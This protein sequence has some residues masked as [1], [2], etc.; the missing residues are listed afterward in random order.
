MCKNTCYSVK[1]GTSRATPNRRIDSNQNQESKVPSLSVSISR[2]LWS[3]CRFHNC[4]HL[5]RNYMKGKNASRN[6]C[7]RDKSRHDLVILQEMRLWRAI[8]RQD[9]RYLLRKGKK[10]RSR[11]H[12]RRVGIISKLSH[13]TRLFRQW[14][15]TN[16]KSLRIEYLW[17]NGL[18]LQ[19]KC[20][21]R[22]KST[23]MW[24]LSLSER[25]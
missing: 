7:S 22:H 13:S 4:A 20:T 9:G 15:L 14:W 1:W 24:R 5:L 6:H 2:M 10:Y 23:K 21:N 16:P 12:P 8:G 3:S 25:T 18:S 17:C 19:S 11:W